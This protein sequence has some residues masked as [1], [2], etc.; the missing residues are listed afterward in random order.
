MC[1]VRTRGVFCDLTEDEVAE[2][3]RGRTPNTYRKHSIIFYEGN[4]AMGLF[5]I[6]SGKVKI[7]NHGVNG[8]TQIVRIGKPGDLLGY[9][10]LFGEESYSA[11]AEVIEDAVICFIDRTLAYSIL[12]RNPSVALRIMKRVCRDLRVAE[13]R[14]HDL[15]QKPVV[16]RVASLLLDLEREFGEPSARGTRLAIELTRE[17]LAE[18][19]GTTAESLIR[20][21]SDFK[22]KG[23]VDIEGH[24]ISIRD[25]ESLA[26]ILPNE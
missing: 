3:M 13:R 24:H 25:S 18:M 6:W 5:G 4:P 17:E 7:F 26:D 16:Q 9:R 19:I 11:T 8:R 22:A 20:T 10:A 14:A 2:L 1:P 12:R 15:V 21:L 23:Y